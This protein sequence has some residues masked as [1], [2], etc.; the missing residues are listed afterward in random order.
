MEIYS[1]IIK[2]GGFIAYSDSSWG[3]KIPYP[4]FGF[5]IYL[6]GGIVSFASKQLKVVA[7]SSCEAEY[8][9]SAYTCKE[10]QF[11]RSLCKDLGFELTASLILCVDNTAAIEVA[12][13][14][15]VT[16][17]TK[18]FEMCMHYFRD[19]VQDNKITPIHILTA[20]QR[21]DG[22]TKGLDKTKYLNWV[23]MLYSIYKGV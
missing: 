16:A 22:F 21:A 18:H 10:I 3:N 4:M 12:N 9:A 17:K 11:I 7:F 2:N 20:F 8:A 5:C 15:G 1:N 23:T 19:L 6:F 14:M 13:N